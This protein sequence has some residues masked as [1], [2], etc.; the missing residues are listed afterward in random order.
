MCLSYVVFFFSSRRRH[1]RCGRDWSSD[2]CSSDLRLHDLLEAQAYRLAFWRTAADEINYRR[3]F[4]INDLA[5]LRQ[6]NR[7]TFYA[8]S[9]ERR[10]GKECRSRWWRDHCKKK[11]KNIYC[12]Q[13]TTNV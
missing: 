10:V 2:V 9:E 6:E 5:A 7:Q 1:T 3:F 4:D 8:R 11:Q 13:R 12:D